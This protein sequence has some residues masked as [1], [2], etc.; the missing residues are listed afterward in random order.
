MD[1]QIVE[2]PSFRIVGR[3]LRVSTKDGEN[4]RAIPDFWQ[5]CVANGTL[6]QL[7]ALAEKSG[8]FAG[9]MLGACT[10]FASDMSEFTYLI[11]AESPTAKVP[12]SMVELVA[13]AS[14]WAVFQAKG[15]VPDSIQSAWGYIM[16]EFLPSGEYAHAAGPD[17]EVYPP[18]DPM[19]PSYQCS[20]WV[21]VNKK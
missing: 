9:D 12:D 11:A 4:M 13:P 1:Y 20:I 18:G 7:A 17:L 10:D 3:P 14:T 8:V 15:A 6:G 19:Q 5:E 16:S 2:K 21:P